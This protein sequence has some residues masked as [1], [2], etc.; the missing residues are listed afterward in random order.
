[1]ARRI[2]ELVTAALLVAVSLYFPTTNW[3]RASLVG[4][5]IALFVGLIVLSRWHSTS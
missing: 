4:L 2:V 1:M 3:G 5:V